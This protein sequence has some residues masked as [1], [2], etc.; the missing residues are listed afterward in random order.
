MHLVPA[1]GR[2]RQANLGESEVSPVY[3][4]SSRTTTATHRETLPRKKKQ[5]QQNKQINKK[6]EETERGP[7]ETP[8]CTIYMVLSLI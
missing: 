5:Q 8:L 1:H 2:Q 6:K 3:G 7:G 4:V